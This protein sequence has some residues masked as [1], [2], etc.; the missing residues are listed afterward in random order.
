M[1]QYRSPSNNSDGIFPYHSPIILLSFSYRSPI[2]L[3]SFSYRSPI[4]KRK[5]IRKQYGMERR[6]NEG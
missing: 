6:M 3:L 1:K 2:V 5:T 4:G